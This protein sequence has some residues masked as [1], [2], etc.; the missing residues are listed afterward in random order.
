MIGHHPD[1]VQVDFKDRL[2]LM[3]LCHSTGSSMGCP[4]SGATSFSV[5][6]RQWRWQKCNNTHL[7]MSPS[8]TGKPSPFFLS[9]CS[10][11]RGLSL[12]LCTTTT[13]TQPSSWKR[14]EPDAAGG[15]QECCVWREWVGLALV[16]R[17]TSREGLC[18]C[19]TP[20]L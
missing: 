3:G 11:L 20:R 10:M 15:A 6:S 8:P 12:Q 2:V 16:F 18:R 9:L 19:P 4:T 5:P 17:D 13:S 1:S 7:R 14:P